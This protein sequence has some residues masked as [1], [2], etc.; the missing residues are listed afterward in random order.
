MSDA[1]A[2]KPTFRTQVREFAEDFFG[3]EFTRLNGKQQSEA[4][5]RYYLRHVYSHTVE[6]LSADEI[7]EGYC[8][9][10]DAGA[11]FVRRDNGRVVIIQAKYRSDGNAPEILDSITH[12]QDVLRRLHPEH[13][14]SANKNQKLADIVREI[15]FQQ[16]TFHLEYITLGRL[17]ESAAAALSQGIKEIGDLPDL[18]SRATLAFFDE[19]GLN[20]QLRIALS[21]SGG[22]P[23]S[24]ELFVAPVT[25]RSSAVIEIEAPHRTLLGVIS[26]TVLANAY[27]QFKEPLFTLNI[28][29]YLGRT[30]TNR[31]IVA[32]IKNRPEEFLNYNNG[33]ACVCKSYAW[34]PTSRR[35]VAHRLQ[36]VNGAQTVRCLVAAGAAL[37]DGVLVAF[38]L[39]AIEDYYR[40]DE[41]RFYSSVIRYSNTQNVIKDVDFRSNDPVQI[42]LQ[43][44][45]AELTFRGKRVH[46]QIKR[47][48]KKP[49]GAVYTIGIGE[50]CKNLYAFFYNPIDFA[51]SST[52]LFDDAEG[53]GYAR[54]F[55][56]GRSVYT[57]FDRDQF[58]EYSAAWF[59]CALAAEWR[60]VERKELVAKGKHLE[61][62]ALERTYFIFVALRALITKKA[63]DADWKAELR[64]LW[65]PDWADDPGSR[66][67]VAARELYELAR[68]AVTTCYQEASKGDGFNHRNWTRSERTY[69]TIRSYVANVVPEKF[70]SSL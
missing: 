58:N 43:K 64:K 46:Y 40:A 70:I 3:K 6:E 8:D 21:Q 25:G 69:E 22:I 31:E 65:K 48:D 5:L 47:T 2:K 7:D 50:L 41:E 67:Y 59:L 14:R 26:G 11:D 61:A 29:S 13:G 36:I 15:D 62:A 53:R 27:R 23:E 20:T 18:Q 28:R 68:G 16:D 32:T 56:D 19:T 57:A 45:F 51:S 35:L 55:G 49:G 38:K 10:T 12:F 1:G 24:V 60:T 66:K 9:G 37:T 42:D 52:F 54:L 34:E 17:Q 33:I 4:V 39:T 44:R 30:K 63:G